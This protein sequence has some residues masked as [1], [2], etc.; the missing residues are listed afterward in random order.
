MAVFE[1]GDPP[2]GT[3]GFA[4]GQKK[5]GIGMPVERMPPAVHHPRGIGC[6][7][8]HPLR[9]VPVYEE[10]QVEEFPDL[11]FTP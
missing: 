8:R 10:R 4:V 1:N 2:R 6:Q 9:A 5:R 7:R 11:P 3:R